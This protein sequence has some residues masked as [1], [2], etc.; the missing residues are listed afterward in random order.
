[1]GNPIRIA[2]CQFAPDV[3]RPEANPG[4]AREA[5]AGAVA[6][7]A[8]IVILPELCNSGYVFDSKEEARAA[9]VTPESE[10]LQGWAEEARQG[11]AVVI[12]GF[13]ELAPDGSVYN[14]AAV[15]DG[16]GIRTV[17]RKLHLWNQ[18]LRWFTPGQDP[19]PVVE[20][21]HGRIGL[22][23]CYDIEFPELTRGLALQ[24][25][26]LIALPANWP[27]DDP[28]PDSRPILHSLAAMTAY[29]NKVF[30]G[31]CDRCG[32][33]RGAEFEGGSVIA[34]P[35]G[36]LLAGPV[37]TRGI[38]TIAADCDLSSAR[39]KRTSASNDAFADRRPEHYSGA[40]A[41]R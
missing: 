37:A 2:C 14:S 30:V 40:L 34:G 35:H 31:V 23:I 19:A 5:I 4:L 17:Y 21:R 41:E 39:D 25:A 27:H 20:T 9:A 16:E 36:G 11:D 26:E 6:D 32:K 3:E 18:E 1:M 28:S 38:E 13:A 12:G 24:G 15:V 8:R 22:A 29:F 7:G 33:E 10:L